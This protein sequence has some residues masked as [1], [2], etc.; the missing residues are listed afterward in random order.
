[1][2]REQKMSGRKKARGELGELIV[3]AGLL[4]SKFGNQRASHLS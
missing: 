3:A 4:V 1:M 2:D